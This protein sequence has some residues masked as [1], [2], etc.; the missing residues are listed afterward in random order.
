MRQ[1]SY[2]SGDSGWAPRPLTRF[3]FRRYSSGWCCGFSHESGSGGQTAGQRRSA[4]GARAS[5]KAGDA[6]ALRTLVVSVTPALP[7]AARGVLGAL[8]P[9]VED[10]AQEAALGFTRALGDYREDS[11]VLHYA[12]RIGVLSALAHRRRLRA[13]GEG[14][15]QELDLNAL[16]L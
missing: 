16:H 8:H 14:L 6:V 10:T 2:A 9:D 7:R 13:R 5:A 1:R 4:P 12:T 11:S 3:P 15:H